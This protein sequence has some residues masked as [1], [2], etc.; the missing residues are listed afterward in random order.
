MSIPSI[1]TFISKYSNPITLQILSH[2]TLCSDS[3]IC[4][5]LKSKKFWQRLTQSIEV[6]RRLSTMWMFMLM[7]MVLT[8]ARP[9]EDSRAPTNPLVAEGSA[10]ARVPR[11]NRRRKSKEITTTEPHVDQHVEQSAEQ[12]ANPPKR[13]GPSINHSVTRYLQNMPEGFKIPLTLDK[14]TKA[15]IGTSATDF[16]TEL[17]I[18][19][20]DVF[21]M[22][23]HKW[24]SVPEDVKTLMYEKLEGKFELLRTD[25]VLME[26]VNSRLHIQ[27]KRSRGVLS[28]H[29]KNN[30]GKTNPRL[31]RLNMHGDCRNQ[32][33]WNHLCD[34]WESEKTRKY[35]DQMELNR[36]KQVNISRGGSRSIANHAFKIRN[37][38]TQLPPSPLEVYYKLHYNAKKKGWL[39][40]D[41]RIVYDNICKQKEEAM[42]RLNTEGT[43]VTTAMEHDVE[44]KAIKSVCGRAKTIQSAWEVGV[45]PVLRK[46]DNWMKSAV[47]SSQR[48]STENED[49]RN[50]VTELKEELKQ[51][52][53]KYERVTQFLSQKYPDFESTISTNDADEDDGLNGLHNE[54]D[55]TI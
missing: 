16:A 4:Q 43:I 32:D 51:S 6:C 3:I 33:D 31:A 44:R 17:G 42:A 41:S 45:G 35:S 23:F 38:E 49:L 39:N 7:M 1:S 53:E 48:D 36:R 15:F 28:Q 29:W 18:I 9:E 14:A 19:V 30:G 40:E 10:S 26:Y 37:P 27:W 8:R 22:R 13:R 34:Y 24:D 47:E 5:L 11:K 50:E 55:S 54:S 2:E 12:H 46:K 21:P 25:N 52:N 20:R